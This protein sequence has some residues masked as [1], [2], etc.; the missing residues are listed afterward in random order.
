VALSSYINEKNIL[1]LDHTSLEFR[2]ILPI[3]IELACF[4]VLHY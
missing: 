4:F 1:A 2:V 3:I